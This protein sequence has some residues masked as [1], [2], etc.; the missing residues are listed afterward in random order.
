M[1]PGM[2]TLSPAQAG[3]VQ[4]SPASAPKSAQDSAE[5]GMVTILADAAGM[6][7]LV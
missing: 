4:L 5:F 2:A 1:L 7:M 3:A 6:M